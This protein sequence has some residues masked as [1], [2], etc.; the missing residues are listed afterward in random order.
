VNCLTAVITALRH[1]DGI[2]LLEAETGH[3]ACTALTLGDHSTPLWQVGQRVTLAFREI[4]VAL[5]RDLAGQ[6]S[7]RN[8]LPCTV[9][10]VAHGALMSRIDLTF[11][12]LAL[13]AV[14]TRG[15]AERLA[16]APGVAVAA[17]IKAN[18][19]HILDQEPT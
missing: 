16:L 5:A 2:L 1:H 13:Q 14:I 6:L 15:S 10:A 19:M 3:G 9:D 11:A 7:L 17:L 8:V 18:D 4:D 12:G